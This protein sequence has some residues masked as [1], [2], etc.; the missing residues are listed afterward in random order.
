MNI[1]LLGDIVGPSGRKAIREKL[2]ELI[3]KKKIDFVIVKFPNFVWITSNNSISTPDF[4]LFD[5]FKYKCVFFN[6]II[7]N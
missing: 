4:S 5:R 1:L 2:P 3:K 6:Q 7:I